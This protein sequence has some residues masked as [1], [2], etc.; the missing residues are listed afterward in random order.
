MDPAFTPGT[1]TPVPGGI[2]SLVHREILWGLKG[3]NAIGGDVVEVSPP[4]DLSGSTANVASYVAA[5]TM[6]I[7]ADA[8]LK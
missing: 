1:G 6:Y 5:D 2:S 3:I 4:Y 8:R 7:L